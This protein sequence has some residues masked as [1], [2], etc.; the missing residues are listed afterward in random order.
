MASQW[1]T[2]DYPDPLFYLKYLAL[3]A[4]VTAACGWLLYGMAAGGVEAYR[5]SHGEIGIPGT[6]T[7]ERE[8]DAGMGMMA[9]EGTFTPDD[10]GAA[11]EAAIE[12]GGP[13]AKGRTLDAW[14]VENEPIVGLERRPTAWGD[15]SREWI[16]YV[17]ALALIGLVAL[18]VGVS[19]GVAA[20]ALLYA[21]LRDLARL[22][23]GFRR[24]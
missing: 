13:C 12:T 18:L 14:L 1:T 17:I 9:C 11:V 23:V 7:I 15:D 22:V 20:V 19:F 16:G 10:G 6:V 24:P 21:F 2:E 3:C 8:Y 5:A 4:V